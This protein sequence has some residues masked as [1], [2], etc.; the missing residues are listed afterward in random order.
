MPLFENWVSTNHFKKDTCVGPV[1]VMGQR[2]VRGDGGR[3]LKKGLEC[4][5]YQKEICSY[6][7]DFLLNQ[8]KR[9]ERKG[10]GFE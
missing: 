1:L 6:S 2:T 5:A 7:Q 3:V 4:S 8:W 9:K 10:L